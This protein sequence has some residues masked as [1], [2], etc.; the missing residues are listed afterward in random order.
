[1]K[2]GTLDWA[3]ERAETA[4]EGRSSS[5]QGGNWLRT[6]IS[7]VDCSSV[8]GWRKRV[9]LQVFPSS[10]TNIFLRR[11]SSTARVDLCT[12]AYRL[13][14]LTASPASSSSYVASF[15]S[16]SF[17]KLRLSCPPD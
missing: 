11:R 4:A 16:D 14:S 15:S 6:L 1:M 9:S 13:L 17:A 5:C 10:L 7:H 2:R 12:Q 3:W 8:L